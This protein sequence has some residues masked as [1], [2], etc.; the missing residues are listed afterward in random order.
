[1][2]NAING[3]DRIAGILVPASLVSDPLEFGG[4]RRDDC[5]AGDLV[6]KEG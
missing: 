5:I 4:E 2:M 1:M 6:L 3:E